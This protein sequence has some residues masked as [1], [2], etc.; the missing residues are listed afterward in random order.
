MGGIGDRIRQCR[1]DLGL[2]KTAVAEAVGVTRQQVHKWETGRDKPGVDKIPALCKLFRVKQEWLTSGRHYV[3]EFAPTT[4]TEIHSEIKAALEGR[5]P[6]V[7]DLEPDLRRIVERVMELP[8]RHRR[9]FVT[10]AG[11]LVDFLLDELKG[12]Q[13][14]RKKKRA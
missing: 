6:R 7:G 5:G 9:L 14:R 3:S 8:T 12:K 10:Q 1:E 2:T 4:P 13:K 11:Q